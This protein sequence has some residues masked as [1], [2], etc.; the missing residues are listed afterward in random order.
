MKE[1][2]QLYTY[3]LVAA[4]A[5]SGGGAFVV[6]KLA[7]SELPPETVAALRYIV[8][9]L[10]FG[11]LVAVERKPWTWPN[12]REWLLLA[13]MGLFVV[14]GYNLLFLEGLRLA[15][16]SEGG[17]LVPGSAPI[18]SAL[19]TWAVFRERPAPRAALGLLLASLGI[20][21]LLWGAGSLAGGGLARR[22]G[23]FFYI[24]G[25]TCWGAFWC[26]ARALGGRIHTL[27]ANLLAAVL[28]LV[29][30]APAGVLAAGPHGLARLTPGLL[31][32][33]AYLAVFATVLLLWSSVRGVERL[34]VARVAPIAYVAPVTAVALSALVLG[35]RPLPVQLL[36]GALAL[37]GTWLATSHG[38][39]AVKRVASPPAVDPPP[40]AG[41][42]VV[43]LV[44]E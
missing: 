40:G 33:V 7:V 23:E 35:E 43:G 2:S 38:R 14:A 10:L 21:L 15:P 6:G 12:R 22:E 41:K 8:A 26:C 24:L 4:G 17:L 25:G 28:G 27:A 1:R 36:G 9:V 3:A 31:A 19:L 18:F 37:L 39:R 42:T 11:G 16:A 13:G 29:L 5:A 44:R 32:A 20:G 30:L 34:G